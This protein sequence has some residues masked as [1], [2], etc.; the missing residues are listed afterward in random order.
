M[1][2]SHPSLLR[3]ESF[4]LTKPTLESNE[5]RA[6]SLKRSSTDTALLHNVSLRHSPAN[7]P[8]VDR[9]DAGHFAELIS[10]L[11]GA[12]SFIGNYE[13]CSQL[14]MID[15]RSPSVFK[16]VHVRNAISLCVPTTLLK[17]PAFCLDRIL[18][19]P[20][21]CLQT[22][23]LLQHQ[24][25]SASWI[26]IYDD[27]GDEFGPAVL[28][29]RKFTQAIHHRMSSKDENYSPPKVVCLTG[30]FDSILSSPIFIQNNLLSTS[31][32]SKLPTP[33]SSRQPSSM[34]SDL[35]VQQA[36]AKPLTCPEWPICLPDY[37]GEIENKLNKH[38]RPNSDP[39][40]LGHSQYALYSGE[41]ETSSLEFSDSFFP[42][43]VE[44]CSVKGLGDMVESMFRSLRDGGQ[45]AVDQNIEC[46]NCP[47]RLPP[48]SLLFNRRPISR[49]LNFEILLPTWLKAVVRDPKI[50]CQ[51]FAM[52]DSE[53]RHRIKNLVR[54]YI[55]ESSHFEHAARND[56]QMTW[57]ADAALANPMDNRYHN[58]WPFD[59]SRVKLQAT[60]PLSF[61]LSSDVRFG[62]SRHQP[63][64][65]TSRWGK[66]E[67]APETSKSTDNYINA[68]WVGYNKE[69]IATQAPVKSTVTSF[70]RLVWETF[71]MVIVMLTKEMEDGNEKCCRYWPE[72]CQ[73]TS[74]VVNVS[75]ELDIPGFGIVRLVRVWRDEVNPNILVR[76]ILAVPC[77]SLLKTPIH[78][79]FDEKQNSRI[80]HQ[81]VF[82]EWPDHGIPI[83]PLGILRLQDLVES[84]CYPDHRHPLIVHCSAGCGRTG[85]FCTIDTVIRRWKSSS[86]SSNLAE[87]EDLVVK[88]VQQ[89]RKDRMEMVQ[90]VRQLSFCYEVCAWFWLLNMPKD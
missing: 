87:E 57:T 69:Y 67:D 15:V 47:V 54:N 7:P 9:I 18:Q 84:L 10:S 23:Q 28:L 24:W 77:L 52:I 74:S 85:S 56:I 42:N 35:D 31:V 71:S 53:E 25:P 27:I 70:W 8:H 88:T 14:V 49:D 58:I 64:S 79:S 21:V 45:F 5:I 32:D 20:T 37:F 1:V 41:F 86:F 17:R 59:H 68:S 83:N 11:D 13:H 33:P 66:I 50:I 81:I 34:L 12:S 51:Q 75:D 39:Q 2:E 26:V 38:P 40:V 4:P 6:L 16:R 62:V 90:T 44:Q 89:L 29:T 60:W 43:I 22:R 63:F 73:A 55:I 61:S 46:L 80:I 36:S 72:S 30:G 76:E 78:G 19:S 48:S 3:A 65:G 82:E